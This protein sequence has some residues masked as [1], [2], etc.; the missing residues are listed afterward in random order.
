MLDFFCGS[1]YFHL[2]LS[3]WNR[4]P[5]NASFL[6]LLRVLLEGTSSIQRAGNHE[7]ISSRTRVAFTIPQLL[8]SNTAKRSTIAQ[9]LQ[10][11]CDV[12]TPIPLYLGLALHAQDRQ[13]RLIG[14]LHQLVLTV[15]YSLIMDVRKKFTQAVS[16]RFKD[17][18][19]VVP[20]NCKRRIFTT[21]T[22]DNTGVSGR[23]DM[24][25]TSITLIGHVTKGNAGI[26][27]LPWM[28]QMIPQLIYLMNLQRSL[29]LKT[30][31]VKYV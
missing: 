5:Q 23:H 17:E 1:I 22:T 19:V 6:T 29:M 13:K 24:H 27:P 26:E 30:L 25:G 21:A 9:N 15:F 18:G 31:E 3:L 20:T 11:R 10:Q 4:C 8:I 7:S 28:F 14:E 16:K 12:K 2:D